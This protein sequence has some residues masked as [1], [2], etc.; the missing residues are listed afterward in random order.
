MALKRDGGRTAYLFDTPVE[1]L[2]ICEYMPDAPGDYVKVYLYALMEAGRG[3]DPD[4][5]DL[6]GELRLSRE[7][8]EKA[9]LYFEEAGVIKR[10]SGDRIFLSLKEKLYGAKRSDERPPIDEKN[11][12]ILDNRPLKEMFDEI[13]RAVGRFLGA[14]E[15]EAIISWIK[16]YDATTEIVTRAYIYCAARGKTNYKYVEKVVKDWVRR[17]FQTG[18]DVEKHLGDADQRHYSYR[19]VMKALG[20]HRTATEEE[21]RIMDTWLDD[22][23]CSMEDILTACSKTAGIPNPNINYVNA[24]ITNRI[25]DKEKGPSRS[26][27]KAQYE[28]MR[29]EAEE[30]A[31]LAKEEIYR[32]IPKIKKIE[33]RLVEC[34]MELTKAMIEGEA[35]K[36]ER[37]TQIKEEVE[38][39]KKKKVVLLTENNV[40]VDYANVKYR[41][42]LC[43]DT[44]VTEDGQRCRCYEEVAEEAV[45]VGKG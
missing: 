13:Q 44:G 38:A 3:G 30:R 10:D 8:V 19:R 2:F 6:A 40:P 23:N 9:F 17:G 36:G 12:R 1:N 35:D 32:K 7:D 34:S 16:D 15:T 39:L 5:D 29:R 22:L 41:C 33:D 45:K 43:K 18:E 14:T 27:V 20:F 37:I 24:V 11:R 26:V 28:S 4:M 31:L 25:K 42:D 21:K